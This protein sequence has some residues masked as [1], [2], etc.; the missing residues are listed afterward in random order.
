MIQNAHRALNLPK[1]GKDGWMAPKPRM[2]NMNLSLLLLFVLQDLSTYIDEFS[3]ISR[4]KVPQNGSLVKIRHVGHI[5]KSLHF[6]W[7]HLH[8]LD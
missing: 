3:N 2:H 5:F 1:I 6:W 7:V 4:L 8:H